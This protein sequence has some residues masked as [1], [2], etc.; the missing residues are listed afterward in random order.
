[1][2]KIRV[3]LGFILLC[4]FALDDAVAEPVVIR[5]SHIVAEQTPKS[6]GANRFKQLVEEKLAGRIR[7][8]ALWGNRGWGAEEEA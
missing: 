7:A 1:V 5:F 4:S 3:I 6:S 2:L 8:I